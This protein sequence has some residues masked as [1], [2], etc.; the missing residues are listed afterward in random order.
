VNRAQGDQA[1][2]LGCGAS[3]PPAATAS[4][5][6]AASGNEGWPARRLQ[7]ELRAERRQPGQP[8]HRR[9]PG[10]D[11]CDAPVIMH[12]P[13]ASIVQA[14]WSMA[15]RCTRRRWLC[16]FM[17]TRPR[18]HPHADW[19]LSGPYTRAYGYSLKH[20][21]T[22]TD[23]WQPGASC[24]TSS[25]CCP[26]PRPRRP[27]PSASRSA[28]LREPGPCSQPVDV[29]DVSLV[30]P[31]AGHAYESAWPKAAHANVPP[32]GQA[33][34]GRLPAPW[35]CGALRTLRPGCVFVQQLCLGRE[36]HGN[37]THH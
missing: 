8:G 12:S 5:L 14:C 19:P 22:S 17:T 21:H 11:P 30:Y 18:M 25:A 13:V 7:R 1:R 31:C 29:P 16:L 4:H 10:R 36:R 33:R 32:E 15:L 35:P 9:Q 34:S 28:S 37:A 2:T 6:V 23:S 24:D 20:A 27:P 3:V 26:P